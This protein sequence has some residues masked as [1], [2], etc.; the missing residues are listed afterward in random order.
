MKIGSH[1]RWW[2][3]RLADWEATADGMKLDPQ[4][5]LSGLFDMATELPGIARALL[6]GLQTEGMRHKVLE[7]LVDGISAS[8]QRCL[9]QFEQSAT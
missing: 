6:V 7:R 3:V 5:A 1:Y 9:R 8:C 2:D 4:K